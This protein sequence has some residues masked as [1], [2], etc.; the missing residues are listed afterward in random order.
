[1]V[2]CQLKIAGVN[3]ICHLSAVGRV[4][5]RTMWEPSPG[6]GKMVPMQWCT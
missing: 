3:S 5:I 6:K 4:Q 1:M 2:V